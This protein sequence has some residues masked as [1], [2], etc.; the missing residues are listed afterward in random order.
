M[1]DSISPQQ[2]LQGTTSAFSGDEPFAS[3]VRG[4]NFYGCGEASI[5]LETLIDGS[6]FECT[7][8]LTPARRLLICEI[9]P[10]M[11]PPVIRLVGYHF[12]S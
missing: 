1:R 10:P 5:L 7:F 9:R 12:K 4:K 8:Q 3:F 11:N 2:G 6:Q